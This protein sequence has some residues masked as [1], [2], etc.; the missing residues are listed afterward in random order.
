[1][2]AKG[3]KKTGCGKYQIS[4]NNLRT[5]KEPQSWG[6]KTLTFYLGFQQKKCYFILK[7]VNSYLFLY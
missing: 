7:E 4:L 2:G 1:M 3:N 6:K 5:N